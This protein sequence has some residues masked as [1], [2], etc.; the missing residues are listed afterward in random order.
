MEREYEILTSDGVKEWTGENGEDAC[1]RCAD[2]L[3]VTVTVWR[4]A[5]A[6]V[7]VVHHSQIIG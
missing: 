1:R 5:P 2:C 3:G 7:A 4:E 6:L